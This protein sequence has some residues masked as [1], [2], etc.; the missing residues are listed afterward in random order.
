MRAFEFITGHVIYNSAY[1]YKFQLKTNLDLFEPERDCKHYVWSAI[2]QVLLISFGLYAF[3]LYLDID[4]IKA[5]QIQ[6][7]NIRNGT[8]ITEGL[9]ANDPENYRLSRIISIG[10][11]IPSMAAYLIL[12]CFYFPI[13]NSL[14]CGSCH[15]QNVLIGIEH[16]NC[17]QT[18]DFC[19][20]FAIWM[21]QIQSK[22]IYIRICNLWTGQYVSYKSVI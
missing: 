8:N 3:D 18:L 14:M 11:L 17:C 12:S 15:I 4:L 20:L 7:D 6:E 19:L 13:P 5:Y 22:V 1:T 9:L 10:L 16:R 21:G 2:I